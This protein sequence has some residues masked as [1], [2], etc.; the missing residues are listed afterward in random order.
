MKALVTGASAVIGSHLVDKLIEEGVKVTCLIRPQD[1]LQWLEGRPVSFITADLCDYSTLVPAVKD[2]DVIYHLAS[3]VNAGSD[4]EYYQN[5]VHGTVNLLKT[6]IQYNP[7]IKH[8]IYIS[9][10][11]VAG[12]SRKYRPHTE[13]TEPHPVSAYGQ[14]KLS[15]EEAVM[16]SR[17]QIPITIIRPPVVFGPRDVEVLRLVKLAKIGVHPILG[18]KKRSYSM[19]Y[20]KDLVDGI[21][22]LT[23]EKKTIGEI[24]Y[25][26]NNESVTWS[27]L[28]QLIGRIIQK[29]GVWIYFP[30]W[31]FVIAVHLSDKIASLSGRKAYMNSKRIHEL[32]QGRWECLPTKARNEIGFVATT[33]LERAIQETIDWYEEQ[34]MV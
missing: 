28:I 9:S 6:I 27:E 32:T 3:Q 24:Y 31:L 12:P 21:W 19:I 17:G 29:K 14:S 33:P 11:A 10:I 5:N 23:N 18:F 8:F 20:V 15:A 2:K 16:A 1:K 30:L 22:K 13:E 34:G 26:A 25:L 4:E 7:R